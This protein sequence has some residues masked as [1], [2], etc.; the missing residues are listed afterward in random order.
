MRKSSILMA[1]IILFGGGLQTGKACDLEPEK[2][3]EIMGVKQ[4]LTPDGIV[5]VGWP[6][7]D[8][9]VQVDGLSMRPFAGL[10]TWAA[11]Q[12]KDSKMSMVM[13]DTVLFEDEVNPAIDAAFKNGLE[14]TALHN[15]FFF[16]EP[17][18]YFMHIGGLGCPN[19]LAKGVRAVWDAVKE[20]RKARPEL[21]RGFG[22]E[23][24]KYGKLATDRLEAIVG[25]KG[26]LEDEVFKI[27]IGRTAE[28]D[29]MKFG[30][31][32]G[33]TTWAAFAGA[34]DSAVVDGDFAMT[35]EEV[36]PVLKALRGADINIV[37]LHTHMVGET[38]TIYFTHF[39]GKGKA[40]D[41][42]KGLAQAIQAQAD[43][44]KK[45]AGKNN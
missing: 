27:T 41:L 36:Q 2:I 19:E 15:H 17:K 28:M 24:P 29:G 5:R 37:A 42:A 39:W 34:D 14:I 45:V 40:E 12:Q 10:G 32:M 43:V 16:D 9:A 18:V 22:S 3:G 23:A 33:L 1:T 30:G 7:K 31:S 21:A 26:A 35:A 4:T 8:V 11:F 25:S 20:V 13:G 38:P 6:R 44:S